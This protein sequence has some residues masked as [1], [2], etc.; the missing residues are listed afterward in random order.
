MDE[1][2]NSNNS[3]PTENT[4]TKKMGYAA[5]TGS[6]VLPPADGSPA[7]APVEV[8]APAIA[9]RRSLFFRLLIYYLF[10]SQANPNPRSS[11]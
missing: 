10:I 11:R 1:L 3:I 7:P 9:P 5:K 2:Q 4:E 6:Y 8:K